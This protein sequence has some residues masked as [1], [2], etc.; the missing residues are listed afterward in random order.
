MTQARAT[1]FELIMRAGVDPQ[2]VVGKK[3]PPPPDFTECRESGL[4]IERNVSVRLRDGVRIYIDIYRPDG[5]RVR[6]TCPHC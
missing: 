3:A 1:G 6:R 4:H 2:R 5:P